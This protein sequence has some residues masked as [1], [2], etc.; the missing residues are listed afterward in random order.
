[1]NPL[2]NAL[3]VGLVCLAVSGCVKA[4]RGSPPTGAAP[5]IVVAAGDISHPEINNQALTANLVESLKPAAVLVLGDAQYGEG[6]LEQFQ[7]AYEPT[8]G[9]FKNL[10]YPTPGNHEYKS[11]AHGYFAYFGARAG[12]AGRGY[13]SFDLGDWHFI[14]LNTGEECHAIGCDA[15]SA[16]AK[17]LEADLA[18]STKKCTIAYWHHPRFGSGHHARFEPSATFWRLLAS[19]HVELVLNG[20]EHLYERLGA[21]DEAG[22]PTPDGTVELVVGTGG[23]GFTD[24]SATLEPASLVRQNDTFGVVKLSL[25]SD[26]WDADFVPVPGGRFTDHVSGACR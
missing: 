2:V 25:F 22:T 17:W 11:G 12:E 8:W 6:T 18:A 7:H 1:M 23:I 3:R 16:Q 20:H 14:A 13:Y 26:R 10:T 4:P 21:M 19:H 15:E 9:R 24:F 5:L